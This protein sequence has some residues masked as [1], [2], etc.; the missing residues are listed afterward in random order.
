LASGKAVMAIGGF[1][2]SDPSPTLAEFQQYVTEG[3]IHYFVSESDGMGG[4]GGS[5]TI[6]AWVQENFTST[7]IGGQTVYDLTR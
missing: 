1:T 7:T 6:A 5:N 3:R 2:G 4:R